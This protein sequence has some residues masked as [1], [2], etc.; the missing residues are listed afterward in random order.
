[1]LVFYYQIK[2]WT[3]MFERCCRCCCRFI[4][5]EKKENK[6]KLNHLTE[7]RKKWLKTQI[8]L[9]REILTQSTW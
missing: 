2:K 1:M 5:F 6:N 7:R 4:D 3:A 9:K 8:N